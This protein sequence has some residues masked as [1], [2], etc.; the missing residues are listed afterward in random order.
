MIL[1]SFIGRLR[2]YLHAERLCDYI[3][4][5]GKDFNDYLRQGRL[6]DCCVY[7]DVIYLPPLVG[8]YFIKSR[9]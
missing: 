1:P 8:G 9:T 3:S 4:V 2:D 7:K 6:R 5:I